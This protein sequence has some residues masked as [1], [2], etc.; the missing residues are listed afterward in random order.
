ML[1]SLSVA[2]VLSVGLYQG[3]TWAEHP[4]SS[5]MW[6]VGLTIWQ[7]VLTVLLFRSGKKQA[8]KENLIPM[9]DVS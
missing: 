2:Y 3:A 6:I 5:L 8:V 9:R 7:I 4:T 1:W